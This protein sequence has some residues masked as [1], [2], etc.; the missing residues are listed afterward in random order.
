MNY[1]LYYHI[2]LC[3]K[4][5]DI[6]KN[7]KF[8]INYYIIVKI[9]I[10]IIYIFM[11]EYQIFL[12]LYLITIWFCSVSIQKEPFIYIR[13]F[14]RNLINNMYKKYE[15]SF[16]KLSSTKKYIIKQYFIGLIFNLYDLLISIY[17]VC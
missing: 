15:I 16:F 17:N 7:L 12:Y 11:F 3:Y 1:Y 6:L 10:I 5:I 8:N 2:Y 4:I 14:L 9:I 13:I